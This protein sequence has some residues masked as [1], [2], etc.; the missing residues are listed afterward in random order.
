MKEKLLNEP[1]E[2]KFNHV[3]AKVELA[4]ERK[5]HHAKERDI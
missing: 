4:D 3:V 2:E 5:E 1:A